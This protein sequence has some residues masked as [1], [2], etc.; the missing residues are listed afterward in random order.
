[1]RPDI[2]AVLNAVAKNSGLVTAN[3]VRTSL[4]SFF[5]WAL[6][7]GSVDTNPVIGTGRN[8]EQSRDRVLTPAELRSIWK[9]LDEDHFGAIIRLLA[10]T[11][12]R[13]DE[14]AALRWSEIHDGMIVLPGERTKN[15]R[16]HVVPLSGSGSCHHRTPR[17]PKDC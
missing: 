6:E 14:V 12:Q 9:G 10:L 3:R 8:K 15:K 2:A 5:G 11:G 4:M 17:A 13:A 1:M 7:Q 16:A